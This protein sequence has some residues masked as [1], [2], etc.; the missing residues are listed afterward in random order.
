M[1]TEVKPWE[2]VSYIFMPLP[3]RARPFRHDEFKESPGYVQ[4]MVQNG[5]GGG[6]KAFVTLANSQRVIVR[7]LSEERKAARAMQK[8]VNKAVEVNR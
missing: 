4:R 6:Y 7:A 8:R 2:P 1:M 3:T 5:V